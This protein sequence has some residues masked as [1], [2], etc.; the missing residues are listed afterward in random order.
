MMRVDLT[1]PQDFKEDLKEDMVLAAD[2]LLAEGFKEIYVFGSAASS[3][4][5]VHNG[6]PRG[7]LAGFYGVSPF[8]PL[9]VWLH[10]RF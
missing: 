3:L 2:I 6:W 7:G 5:A 10:A 8:L 1:L 4:H 9:C